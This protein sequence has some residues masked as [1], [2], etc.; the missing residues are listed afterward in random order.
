MVADKESSNLQSLLKDY[1]SLGKERYEQAYNLTEHSNKQL[2]T[3][4][5]KTPSYTDRARSCTRVPSAEP[6]VRA[7]VRPGSTRNP[8]VLCGG[9]LQR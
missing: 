3:I 6:L 2:H 5:T 7:A 4:R 9:P 8:C 1:A